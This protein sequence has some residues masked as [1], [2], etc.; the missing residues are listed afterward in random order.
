MRGGLRQCRWKVL[1]QESQHSSLSVPPH[2]KQF[3][4]FCSSRKVD[5]RAHLGNPNR[6]HLQ[7]ATG[8]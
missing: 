5:G 2:T 6:L 8:L 7:V 3:S 1:G 4:S